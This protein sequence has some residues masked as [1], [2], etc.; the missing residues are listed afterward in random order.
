[1]T[2]RAELSEIPLSW[3][4]PP[5]ITASLKGREACINNRMIDKVRMVYNSEACLNKKYSK[6]IVN[7]AQFMQLAD[8]KQMR[9]PFSIK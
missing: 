6:K 8:F 4:G 9:R 7:R 1:M 5:Q 3:E 2:E